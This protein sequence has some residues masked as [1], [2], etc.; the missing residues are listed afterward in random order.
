M[1]S[2]AQ[3]TQR[4]D[5]IRLR[6][7][8]R[9]GVRLGAAACALISLMLALLPGEV[10]AQREV[11]VGV[12]SNPPKIM[13][14]ERGMPSGILGDLLRAM[15]EEEDW[16]LVV[17]ACA[18]QEC[19]DRL[20]AGELDLLPDLAWSEP[21]SEEFAF[22]TVP[23]LHSW[24]QLYTR[25]GNEIES[26]VGIDDKRIALLAGSIQR[27]Y[28]EDLARGLALHV[29]WIESATLDDA[30]AAVLAGEADVLA[31]NHF[32]G[33]WAAVRRG[34]VQTGVIFLPARLHYA[35]P[36]EGA[37][38]LH[39]A[40]DR[41]L[42]A[43]RADQDSIYYRTLRQ[44]GAPPPSIGLPR[45]LPWLVAMAVTLMLGAFVA[46]TWFRREVERKTRSLVASEERLS[47]I[48]NSVDA[49]I[50][51][52]DSALRYTYANH[53]LSELLERPVEQILGRGD[54]D[55]FDPAT[56]AQMQASDRIVFE[57]GER[58][59][60]EETKRL[61]DSGAESHY[62]S[63]KLPLRDADGSITALCGIS[64]D[65]SEEHALLT[66]IHQLAYFDPLTHLPNRQ[67]LIDRLRAALAECAQH[68]HQG[69][70]L[71]L[72]LDRFQELNDT[73]G[74]DVGDEWLRRVAQSLLPCLREGQCAARL[75]ADE[76]AILV[77]QLS[78]SVH[79]ATRQAAAL[80]QALL[81][82]VA[83][84]VALGESDY[85]GSCGIGVALFAG[86]GET[87]EDVLKHADIALSQ[88]KIAGSGRVR[89]FQPEMQ[90]AIAARAA[91]ES[92]L[93]A[94]LAGE[95]FVLHFQPQFDLHGVLLGA[96]ALL[97]WRHPQR[98][99]VPPGSFIPLAEASGL[100]VPLGA[101]V[102]EQA[103]TQLARWTAHPATRALR[104]A[105][106][107]SAQQ[108]RQPHFVD[109]VLRLIRRVGAPA[110]RLEL[111]LTESELVEDI[112]EAIVRLAALRREGVRI[113]LDDFG[114]GYSALSYIKRLPLDLLKID[115]SFIRDLLLDPNDMAIVKTIIA[116]GGSLDLDVLAEG[117]EEPGQ[118]EVLA[119]LGCRQFQ[120]FLFGS[121]EPIE[122]LEARALAAAG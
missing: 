61:K 20:R 80:G 30:V 25:P 39:A 16:R 84:P 77:P 93:R 64:T 33:D 104:L 46:L 18:W 7:A 65:I 112:E 114:T 115:T 73:R 70:L 32:Y 68:A 85:H 10:L 90:T 57:R 44:W 42:E 120:G 71:L 54:E 8:H 17:V 105:V 36:R 83:N 119:E 95:Q 5:L 86:E 45:Y 107:V 88:A 72:N 6:A 26:M 47:T 29:D 4:N 91:L 122:Q 14:D 79:E 82:G 99:L 27:S 66:E 102:L 63:V 38:D 113:A 53:R 49:Q 76:F 97:R 106:N 40:I 118:R 109:D 111:E 81:D 51:I 41:H 94:A 100:I 110:D 13:L 87:A 121:A 43:W 69:A 48:L 67:Q 37:A 2:T 15:A 34:L 59:A 117:V 23:A 62:F 21:R 11:R 98:G 103:C 101:W 35:G 22:H 96:E 92:E 3:R 12:Y 108:L 74:H 24:S 52:K 58:A 116:L 28:M 31:T 9:L 50:Y 56:A 1:P 19:L 60:G 89:F 75:G 55:F 78:A